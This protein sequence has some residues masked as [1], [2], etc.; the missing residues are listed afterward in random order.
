MMIQLPG[1][2]DPVHHAQ[3]T[4]RALLDGLARPGRVQTLT[5][6][7]EPPPGLSRAC[8]AAC[9]TLL[10]LETQV[11]LQPDW[12]DSVRSWLLFHTGCR[13]T[14]EPKTANFAVL[15][16]DGE[17][18]QPDRLNQSDLPDL[19]AFNPGNPEYPEASTTLLMQV[20]DLYT[21]HPVTLQG[22]GILDECAIAPRLSAKFWQFWQN[23]HG[24]YPLG[25]DIFL[26]ADDQI[27][28]L[29][30]S[31]AARS[32]VDGQRCP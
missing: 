26:F 11:W 10:D 19:T 30:R 16:A 20:A 1:F 12:D 21:G 13:F 14:S 3:Q 15:R 29:P 25:V 31:T 2:R 9:L 7:L 32:Q 5:L 22:P 6:D 18:N 27:M 28:G 23:N 8:A 4:F 17:A 24:L